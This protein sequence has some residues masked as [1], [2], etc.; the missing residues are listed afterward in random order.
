MPL[1]TL[2]QARN[3]LAPVAK[4]L[5]VDPQVAAIKK[6][7]DLVASD[8]GEFAAAGPTSRAN[9]IHDFTVRQVRGALPNCEQAREIDALDFFAVAFGDDLLIR[10]KYV[11]RGLPRNVSTGI[12][13]RLRVQQYD[14][15]T[16]EAL[17][18]EHIPTPP[19]I[20]TCGYTLDYSGEV[21]VVSLQ[22]DYGNQV[23]WRYVVWGDTGEGGID[24]YETLPLPGGPSPA[25]AT[26][27]S[28][29]KPARKSEETEKS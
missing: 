13:E 10:Y 12:Q 6:W 25:P 23:F 29:R 21:R 19:T 8:P 16:M 15:R 11:A 17:T 20:T 14:E 9:M 1:M 24:N 26:I 22:C 3:R 27:Q 7:N 2:D 18:L 4:T 5:L 28:A